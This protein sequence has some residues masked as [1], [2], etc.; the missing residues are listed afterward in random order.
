MDMEYKGFKKI[1]KDGNSYLTRCK[2]DV[3]DK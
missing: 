1:W 2:L 3:I